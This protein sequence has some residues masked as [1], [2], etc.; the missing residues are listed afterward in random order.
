MKLKFKKKKKNN[1]L[2]IKRTFSPRWLLTIYITDTAMNAAF[3]HFDRFVTTSGRPS[4]SSSPLLSVSLS[5]TSR[6]YFAITIKKYI[7]ATNSNSCYFITIL[8]YNSLIYLSFKIHH[9]H[10]FIY[11]LSLIIINILYYIILYYTPALL[12]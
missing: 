12:H 11:P 4:S 10:I 1:W 8:Q 3:F 6:N 2:L 7:P 9:S 5:L